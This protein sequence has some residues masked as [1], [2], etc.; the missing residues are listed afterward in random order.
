MI[1]E[2][3]DENHFTIKSGA[4]GALFEVF[5]T[6]KGLEI[7]TDKWHKLEPVLSESERV[8]NIFK[9]SK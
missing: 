4:M 5:V 3:I 1:I 7:E 9:L 6:D 8:V 2:T